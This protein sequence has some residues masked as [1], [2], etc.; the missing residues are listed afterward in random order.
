MSGKESPW[1]KLWRWTLIF[2]LNISL[3]KAEGLG[4][5]KKKKATFK[6]GKEEP[7]KR[8]MTTIVKWL[9]IQE[10]GNTWKN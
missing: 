8:K 4:S 1:K 3:K 2:N 9:W 6:N 7:E 5:S 10:K